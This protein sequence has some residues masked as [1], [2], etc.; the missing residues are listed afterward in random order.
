[1][2]FILYYNL[3]TPYFV[4]QHYPAVQLKMTVTPITWFLEKAS[5]M[6]L[7]CIKRAFTE[8]KSE[9]R[10]KK[11]QQHGCGRGWK[12]EGSRNAE[13]VQSTPKSPHL[14]SHQVLSHAVTDMQFF[15]CSPIRQPTVTCGYL[16]RNSVPPPQ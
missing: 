12:G 5:A 6:I 14:P 13:G 1:M 8:E 7:L 16:T 11:Q 10:G 9:Q 15:L 2:G 3:I 4:R